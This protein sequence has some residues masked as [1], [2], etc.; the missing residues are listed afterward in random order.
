[1]NII[2][3]VFGVYRP[4]YRV[5]FHKNTHN[6]FT[7]GET[8]VPYNNIDNIKAGTLRWAHSVRLKYLSI[9]NKRPRVKLSTSMKNGNNSLKCNSF[10]PGPDT[11]D[12]VTEYDFDCQIERQH[13]LRNFSDLYN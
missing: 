6:T 9:E 13:I 4:P 11:I 1:M 7:S 12:R 5:I 10:W 3:K 8:G 2:L